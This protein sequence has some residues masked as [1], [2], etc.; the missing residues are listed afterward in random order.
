MGGPN[1]WDNPEKAQGVIQ[2][3]K[4][5]NGLINPF[6][7]LAASAEDLNVLCELCAEDESLEAELQKELP[8]IEKKLGEFDLRSLFTGTQDPQNA[9]L[10]ISA[11]TGGT[12]ACDWAQ[13]LLRMYA[14]L[15]R[16]P[17]LRCRNDR[18]TEE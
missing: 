16:T 17:W 3:L 9:F 14:A 7:A 8:A 15:D 5:L 11:G 18:R 4:P 12:E 2:Q 1:F 6:D 13:I 10:K